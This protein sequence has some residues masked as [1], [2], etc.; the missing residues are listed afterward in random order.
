MGVKV[1]I[2]S[3][4]VYGPRSGRDGYLFQPRR[5]HLWCNL[6]KERRM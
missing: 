5:W 2:S 1:N 4:F 6:L 3:V